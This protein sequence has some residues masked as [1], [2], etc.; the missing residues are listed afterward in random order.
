[1]KKGNPNDQRAG[2]PSLP[3]K[4]KLFEWFVGLFYFV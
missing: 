4:A 1:M 2:I 3:G